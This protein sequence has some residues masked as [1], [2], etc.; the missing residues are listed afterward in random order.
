MEKSKLTQ[1]ADALPHASR[2]M[3]FGPEVEVWKIGGKIFAAIGGEPLG[4]T[5]KCDSIETARLLIDLGKA[6]KAPYFHASWI[7]VD[8]AETAQDDA[9][10]RLQESYRLVRGAL[11]KW[12]R[13]QLDDPPAPEIQ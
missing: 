13:T 9:I 12:Q 11:P 2:E 5:V 6:V 7:R 1:I 4:L 3:P 8:L 10:S